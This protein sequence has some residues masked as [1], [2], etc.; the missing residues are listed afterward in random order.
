ML[1]N[2]ISQMAESMVYVV[3]L[4]QNKWIELSRA[5]HR[6]D[7]FPATYDVLALLVKGTSD[8]KVVVPLS[9]TNIYETYKIGDPVRRAALAY[10]QTTLSG[11]LV[12]RGRK[13]QLWEEIL[14]FFRTHLG[15]AA[16][17]P[18]AD[19]FI[20]RLFFESVVEVDDDGLTDRPSDRLIDAMV[21][22]PQHYLYDFLTSAAAQYSAVRT[23]SEGADDLRR[24]VEARR[25][26]NA[27][28]SLAMRRRIYS[29]LLL[30]DDIEF[31]LAA[32]KFAGVGWSSTGDIGSSHGRRLTVDVPSY[33]VERE[34]AVR[35]EAQ[36]RAIN[37][38]DFR[39]MR[40][41]T[42]TIPYAD[43]VVAENQFINLSIQARLG[44]KYGTMIA[45]D[46][47]TLGAHLQGL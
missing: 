28:E 32:A 34:L 8:G 33:Y 20:S 9:F 14:E 21:Q 40:A 6:P 10:V 37:E 18:T 24:R 36:S 25:K 13:R 17:P 47:R 39:D 44:E 11:G 15:F 42:T 29:A 16:P 38:N 4:D 31:L 43:A 19:W 23:Y 35:L 45:T 22:R 26:H 27:Q 30:L 41:F 1:T 7:D 2:A 3:Y 46:L 12:F 5:V